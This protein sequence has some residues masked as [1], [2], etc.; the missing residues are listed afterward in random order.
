MVRK[1]IHLISKSENESLS[2]ILIGVVN[3]LKKVLEK[4]TL[5]NDPFSI[6]I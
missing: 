2:W 5:K 3:E 1:K 4:N 6:I